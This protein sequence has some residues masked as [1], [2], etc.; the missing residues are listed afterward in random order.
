MPDL[1][2]G[3]LVLEDKLLCPKCGRDSMDLIVKMG[4]MEN[5]YEDFMDIHLD[6][7]ECDDYHEASWNMI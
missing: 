3:D 4:T 6:C 7:W 2:V 1:N 5:G